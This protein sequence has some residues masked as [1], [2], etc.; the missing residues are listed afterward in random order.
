MTAWAPMGA[1]VLTGKYTRGASTTPEDSV[2]AAGNEDSLTD[3]NLRIAR[4]VDRTADELGA[5]SAQVAIAWVRQ[6]GKRIIPVVGV[7][8]VEQMHDILGSLDVA[9]SAGQ[10][11]QL[12]EVGRVELG[13]PQD[14]LRAPTG[15]LVYGD[16]EAKIDLPQTAP[17]Y[18]A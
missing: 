12:D 4:E 11:A 10:L 6:R 14:F 2:R 18:G 9:L 15:Q 1:G 13:F 5:T 8:T 3:R 7:R 16:L 17:R